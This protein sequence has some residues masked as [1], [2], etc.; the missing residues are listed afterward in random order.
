MVDPGNQLGE[1]VSSTATENQSKDDDASKRIEI[2]KYKAE[3]H[4]AAVELWVAGM[5][6]G[7]DKKRYPK[8]YGEGTKWCEFV[9]PQY[10]DVQ[11]MVGAENGGCLFSAVDGLGTIVGQIGLK[12]SDEDKRHRSAELVRN[13]VANERRGQGIG[14]LMLMF[15][16]EHAR[17]ELK[18]DSIWLE[19]VSLLGTAQKMYMKYGFRETG[20][21]IRDVGETPWWVV[22]MEKRL[23]E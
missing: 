10:D 8:T 6:D 18:C 22:R 2:R 11:S 4:G 17:V 15:I 12:V 23:N 14:R 19:T 1:M 21:E 9:R 5:L 16:I 7:I 3:D 20:R 13:A